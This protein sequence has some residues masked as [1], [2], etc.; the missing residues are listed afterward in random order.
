MKFYQRWIADYAT[1]TAHLS[2]AEDGIY[3]RLLDHYYSLE[4]PL[5]NDLDTLCRIARAMTEVERAGVQVVA[6]Q[7]F[8]VSETDGLRHN[9]RADEELPEMRRRIAIAQENGRK[10]GRPKG[11]REPTTNQDGNPPG[12]GWV[13]ESKPTGQANQS[14]E[15][16]DER[17]IL[18]IEE[19]PRKRGTRRTLI[20]DG[21]AVSDRL[22]AW[23]FERG[24]DQLERHLE[25]FA[26]KARAGAYRYADWDEALM[27]AIRDD[28]AGIRG[29][30]DPVQSSLSRAGSRTAENGLAVLRAMEVG[31]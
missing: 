5:P 7:F 29:R 3:G 16:V 6:D 8:P 22:R 26:G 20:P 17:K 27:N 24:F 23:A 13:S 1:A 25:S 30:G 18:S 19:R 11:G 12:F 31:T 2:C 28:W 10:G 4:G 9:R 14:Q 15:P 21:F